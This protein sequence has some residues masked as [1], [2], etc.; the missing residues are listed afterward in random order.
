MHGRG[1]AGEL[2]ALADPDMFLQQF[3]RADDA[4]PSEARWDE[5]GWRPWPCLPAMSRFQQPTLHAEQLLNQG[6]SDGTR[7][8]GKNAEQSDSK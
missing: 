7:C 8:L 5:G 6:L 1:E 2:G 3:S 4:L